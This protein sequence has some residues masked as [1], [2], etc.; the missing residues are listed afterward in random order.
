MSTFALSDYEWLL[1]LARADD[2]I[3]L[4]D[5][6]RDLRATDARRHVREGCRSTPGGTSRS[7]SLR[8]C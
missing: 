1:P 2:P 8:R 6:M 5:L 4:V 3:H 7:P